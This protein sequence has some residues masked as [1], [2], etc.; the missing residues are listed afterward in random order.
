MSVRAQRWTKRLAASKRA[1]GVL[2]FASIAETLI[3]P[4]PIEVILVPF[5]L[6]NKAKIWLTAGVVLAGNLVA[7]L[8]GY[9]VGYFAFNSFGRDLIASSGWQDA[10][11]S[12]QGMF[13]EYGFWAIVAIGI[14][15]IPFQ[16][17]MLVAGAAQYPVI[18]F[19]AA[20]ALARG[21]RYFG[22]AAL[23]YKFGDRAMEFWGRHKVSAT[24]WAGV[25]IA[26]VFLAGRYV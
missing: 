16:I 26:A 17:A 9:Y 20:A 11:V 18:W 7:A 6:A 3:V 2:F 21:S 12:F 1:Q 13:A 22:L 8:V 15:P 25:I 4:I 5:M 24:I 10:F 23:V 19:I 14:I